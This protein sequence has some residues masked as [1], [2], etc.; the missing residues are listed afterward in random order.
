MR[1]SSR[2]E[3]ISIAFLQILSISSNCFHHLLK[4]RRQLFLPQI[5]TGCDN[6]P[7]G[8]RS[9]THLKIPAKIFLY[10]G[11][12]P[13]FFQNLLLRIRT[14]PLASVHSF[15][16][17]S[18]ASHADRQFRSSTDNCARNQQKFLPPRVS[19]SILRRRYIRFFN[20]PAGYRSLSSGHNTS[21]SSWTL[22]FFH[23]D[24]SYK[25]GNFV[26][27]SDRI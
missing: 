24:K 4:K 15:S 3:S 16:S 18:S 5:K 12:P 21:A 13:F 9:N 27:I 22:V 17:N 11:P 7:I 14:L 1:L 26:T 19:S 23:G 10:K 20:A 8:T 6:R 25:K 2:G